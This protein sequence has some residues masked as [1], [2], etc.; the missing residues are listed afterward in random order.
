MVIHYN[1]MSPRAFWVQRYE[2][3]YDK[4]NLDHLDYNISTSEIE[5]KDPHK[6]DAMEEFWFVMS[7]GMRVYQA[8]VATDVGPDTLII[9][10]R[11]VFHR[12]ECKDRCEWLCMAF[13]NRFADKMR[14]IREE[15]GN[16]GKHDGFVAPVSRTILT[17]ADLPPMEDH[18]CQRFPTDKSIRDLD[19]WDINTWKP[20]RIWKP[21]HKHDSMEEY[22]YILEGKA[23]VFQGEG[24]DEQMYEVNPHDFVIHP[25]GVTHR[26]ETDEVGC[27]WCCIMFNTLLAEPLKE[28]LSFP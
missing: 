9:H 11:E 13:S 26:M 7:G 10:E 18:G 27:K 16:Y 3:P 14:L 4:T 6:H 19:H 20:N 21:G 2:I 17:S 12:M 22:W 28:L 24:D 1:K 23:R 8:D 15:K 25:P 5:W